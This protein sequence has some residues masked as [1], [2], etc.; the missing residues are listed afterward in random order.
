MALLWPRKSA[1]FRH[2]FPCP[3]RAAASLGPGLRTASGA[4]GRRGGACHRAMMST[5]SNPLFSP[6]NQT[7]D[8][9]WDVDI[10]GVTTYGS[11]ERTSD[12]NRV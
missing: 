10:C 4:K 7:S 11:N 3:F 8:A 1:I 6:Y 5:M 2:F 9:F 12:V